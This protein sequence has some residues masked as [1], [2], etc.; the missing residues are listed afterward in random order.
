M[1]LFYTSVVQHRNKILFRG[2]ENGRRTTFAKHYKPYLFL[3]NPR[4]SGEYKTLK[5]E[6]CE[7]ME[8]ESMWEARD[9]MKK[10][11][12]VAGFDIYGMTN[13]V[14]PYIYDN[15]GQNI[16]CDTS[17]VRIANLDIEVDA[18]SGF[19]RPEEASKVVTA[20][21]VR[22]RG[23]A[24]VLG[25]REYNPKELTILGIKPNDN[26]KYVRCTNEEDL[27]RKFLRM[28]E[29]IDPDIVTGW[30]VNGFD[31][32]YMINR[33]ARILGE[34]DAARMSPW[35]MIEWREVE[36]MGRTQKFATMV[37]ITILDY[38]ELYK[39][40]CPGSRESF[41]L[42]Y[43]GKYEE[44]ETT[45]FNY[46]ELGYKDLTDLFERNFS[47][48]IHYNIDDTGVVEKLE[49]KLKLIAL[50]ITMS[51][52]SGMTYSDALTTV[53]LWDVTIHGYLMSKNIVIP[54]PKPK[55]SSYEGIEGAYVKDPVVGLSRWVVSFDVN[56]LYPSLIRQCNIS[57]ETYVTTVGGITVDNLLDSYWERDPHT[58]TSSLYNLLKRAKENGAGICATGCVF[59]NEVEGFYPHLMSHF[60]SERVRYK[61]LLK[62]AKKKLKELEKSGKGTPEQLEKLH[63]DIASYDM[64]Q[65]SFKIMLNSAYGAL[66]NEAYRWFDPK[67][68]ES[69][70]KSGQF[71]I[72]WVERALNKWLNEYCNTK[73][74]KFV[75]YCDTDSAYLRLDLIVDKLWPDKLPQEIVGLLHDFCEERI[76]PVINQAFKEL[77]DH[78][79]HRQ[80]VLEMKREAIAD[81]AIWTAKKRYIMNVWDMEG[82]RYDEPKLKMQGIEAVKS[83]TPR[84]AREYIKEALK[85]I[86]TKTEKDFIDFMETKRVEFAKLSFDEIAFPRSCNNL[87]KYRDDTTIY[88]KG[89]PIHVRGALVFNHFVKAK[90]LHNE[91]KL[92]EEGDKIKF[93]HMITPNPAGEN[94]FASTGELPEKLGLTNYINYRTQFDKGVVDPLKAI[95][96]AIGWNVEHVPSLDDLFIYD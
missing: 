82:T 77:G 55:S 10:Y 72:R 14:Y 44:L 47:L 78:L 95:A 56:S 57:P 26:V 83:S 27:L 69:V 54:Q 76:Q 67:L 50:V 8:F 52:N 41:K 39:K 28:W 5:G 65:Y 18:S 60:Y 15:F 75:V 40:F 91:I 30:N 23:T 19:P 90:A 21:T 25:W 3:K 63:N 64:Y 1:S 92:I 53:R 80:H 2:Y 94:V 51:Y 17:A 38:L 58:L 16:K 74:H 9:W 93:C 85:V 43:I 22:F 29:E 20:I 34:E 59:D 35:G 70:T 61:G 62:D 87:A 13:W 4:A 37:G 6:P 73:D 88:Q 84:A 86:M 36:I 12:G 24:Y 7:R 31:V 81:K 32:P 79:N 42:E 33:L 71:T 49:Q 46:H 11:Q 89:C 68:S 48:Y 96:D 66:S 45:K